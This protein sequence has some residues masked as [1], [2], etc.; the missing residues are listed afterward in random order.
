MAVITIIAYLFFD[1][2]FAAVLLA[3]FCFY[4]IKRKKKYYLERRI[5][6]LNLTFR[7]ALEGITAALLAGY[8]I[9]N[10]FAE[11]RKDMLL[12]YEEKED[13]IQELSYICGQL[14]LNRRVEDLLLEFAKRSQLEDIMNFT[15]VFIMAKRSGGN[16]LAILNRTAKN[17]GDKIEIKREI[18]TMIAGKKMEAKIMTLIPAGIIAYMRIFSPGFMDSLYHNLMG[19]FIMTA[20]LIL[21]GAG[22]YM[23]ERIVNIEI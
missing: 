12:I 20:A 1:S 8:S 23:S 19:V 15:D 22:F 16:L 6:R 11:A 2:I 17:I 4:Y 7:E 3:P 5:W 14:A 10:S 18:Q 21:Y 13:I 9:E